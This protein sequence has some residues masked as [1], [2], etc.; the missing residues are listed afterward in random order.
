MKKIKIIKGN[1]LQRNNNPKVK[2]V[3]VIRGMINLKRTRKNLFAKP[4]KSIND[5]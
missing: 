4:R 2:A 3:N 5:K 1:L